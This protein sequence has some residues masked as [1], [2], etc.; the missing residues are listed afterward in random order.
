MKLAYI[1]SWLN[2]PSGP[3]PPHYRGF[4]ITLRHITLGRT[5]LDERSARLRDLY[6]RTHNS[7]NRETSM[8]Q[9][10]FEP[11][12]PASEQLQTHKLDCAASGIRPS[13]K[14]VDVSV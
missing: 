13:T 3:G 10:G 4:T 11:T 2:S 5:P 8:T 9:A 6:L 7:Y 12:I 1:F 14:Q